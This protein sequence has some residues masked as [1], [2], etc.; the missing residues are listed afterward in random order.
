MRI[1]DKH[2]TRMSRLIDDLSNTVKAR[3]PAD[4]R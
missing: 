1:I 3:V 4:K 2:A